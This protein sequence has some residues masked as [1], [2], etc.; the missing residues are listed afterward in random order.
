MKFLKMLC[1]EV[2]VEYRENICIEHS[3][4]RLTLFYGISLEL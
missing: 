4:N 1:K 3:L 2:N